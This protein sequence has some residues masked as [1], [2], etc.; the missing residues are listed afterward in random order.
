MRCALTWWVSARRLALVTLSL[1]PASL[2]AQEITLEAP[3]E[4]TIGA[5]VEIRWQGGSNTR[6]F[7][8]IL[9]TDEPECN[10]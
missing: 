9:P 6:D 7:I 1:L 4:V 8:N 2:S 5:P 3:D 10:Y